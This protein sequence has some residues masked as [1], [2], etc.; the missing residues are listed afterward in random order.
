MLFA[1]S[2]NIKVKGVTEI[3]WECGMGRHL[4]EFPADYKISTIFNL[5]ILDF[6]KFDFH[7]WFH[8]QADQRSEFSIS[9]AQFSQTIQNE[10]K[11]DNKV[12]WLYF[13]NWTV[14][15]RCRHF[16][17]V[18][19]YFFLNRGYESIIVFIRYWKRSFEGKYSKRLFQSSMVCLS[20]LT[21]I[22]QN[23]G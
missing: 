17:S 10:Q 21:R 23:S 14:K 5:L 13:L 6:K 3:Q 7:Q 22:R 12:L 19:Q 9:G 11:V 18:S 20:W 8:K 16:S 15:Y 4:S 1:F 2:I